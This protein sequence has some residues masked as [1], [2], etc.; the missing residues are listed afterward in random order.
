MTEKIVVLDPISQERADELR[1]L[2]PEGFILEC[3]RGFSDEDLKSA[4]ADADYAISGQI[5]VSGDVLRVCNASQASSQVGRR[6]R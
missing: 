3:G 2:L 6:C 1:E 4:I 5:G